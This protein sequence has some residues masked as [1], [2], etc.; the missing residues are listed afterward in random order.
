MS[1][2]GYRDGA[3]RP[4]GTPNRV[5][6]EIRELLGPL[7]EPAVDRLKVLID[8]EDQSIALKATELVL[9]YLYGRP[10]NAFEIETKSRKRVTPEEI[11]ALNLSP[12]QLRRLAGLE[13]EKFDSET[14]LTVVK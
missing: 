5:T 12:E 7:D 6:R 1:R 2:G 10:R 13:N 14:V 8:S 3:G 9:G 11:E 4:L